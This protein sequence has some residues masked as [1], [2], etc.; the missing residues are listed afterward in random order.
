MEEQRVFH[1]IVVVVFP[2]AVPRKTLRR[3]QGQGRGV[4]GADFLTAM[5]AGSEVACRLARAAVSSRFSIYG[6]Y[7]PPVFT[8]FGATAA[9]CKLLGLNADQIIDA[10]GLSIVIRLY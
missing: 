3:V 1:R 4:S 2:Q 6:F 10:S 7:M 5:V 8:S 9:A